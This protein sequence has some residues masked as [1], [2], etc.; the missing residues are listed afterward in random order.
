MPAPPI[1]IGLPVIISLSTAVDDI[2]LYGN[3]RPRAK[4]DRVR[5]AGG[6]QPLPRR[7]WPAR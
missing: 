6:D 2:E 3:R 5:A 4:H 1:W 7:T